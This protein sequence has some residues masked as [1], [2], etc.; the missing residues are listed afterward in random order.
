M[1]RKQAKPEKSIATQVAEMRSKVKMTLLYCPGETWSK[2]E[3]DKLMTGLMTQEAFNPRE[4]EY[5]I[6]RDHHSRDKVQ[7]ILGGEKVCTIKPII[8]LDHHDLPFPPSFT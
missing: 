8:G 5:F 3:R 4:P 2:S 6:L 1:K 7:K